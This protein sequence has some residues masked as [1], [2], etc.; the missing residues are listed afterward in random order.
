MTWLR[1]AESVGGHFVDY[2]TGTA[3]LAERRQGWAPA[4][5][6]E[7]DGDVDELIANL[8]TQH[9]TVCYGDF[10]A[11][12]EDIARVLRIPARRI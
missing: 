6:L 5:D 3:H 8:T 10:S 1:F 2:G 7:L 11:E 9:Y 4:V 12:L